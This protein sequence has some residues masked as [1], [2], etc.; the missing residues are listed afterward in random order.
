M[1]VVKLARRSERSGSVLVAIVKR[2]RCC[3]VLTAGNRL[4]LPAFSYSKIACAEGNGDK[5]NA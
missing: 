5:I 4:M 1:A 2:L 3:D